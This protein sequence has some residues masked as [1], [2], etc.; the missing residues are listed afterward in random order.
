MCAKAGSMCEVTCDNCPRPEP[1]PEICSDLLDDE[2]EAMT[3]GL[4]NSC[5]QAKKAGMC[6]KA[7]PACS[8]TCGTCPEGAC[9]DYAPETFETATKGMFK[10]CAEAKGAGMCAKA[11]SMCQVTCKTCPGSPPARRA[12]SSPSIMRIIFS[13]QAL[14]SL[15]LQGPFR[16]PATPNNEPLQDS[17]PEFLSLP[18]VQEL[19]LFNLYHQGPMPIADRKRVE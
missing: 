16:G 7:G 9:K 19:R 17:L 2:F 11:G 14:E 15:V 1:C 8:V 12:V 3:K 13:F 6:E 18:Q 4:F 5:T 10:S